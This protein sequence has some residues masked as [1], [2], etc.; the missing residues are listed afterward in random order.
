MATSKSALT[1]ALAGPPGEAGIPDGS[2]IRLDAASFPCL[3]AAE[4]GAGEDTVGA[5][6]TGFERVGLRGDQLAG[7]APTATLLPDGSLAVRPTGRGGGRGD[8]RARAAGPR[9]P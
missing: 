3:A 7:S 4:A 5:L 6:V 9:L 2:P 8:R 1:A